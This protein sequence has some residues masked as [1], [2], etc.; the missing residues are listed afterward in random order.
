MKVHDTPG[1]A[2]QTPDTCRFDPSQN[3]NDSIP[4]N[5][6][7]LLGMTKHIAL[8]AILFH[9]EEGFVSDLKGK[10]KTSAISP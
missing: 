4:E 1:L 10:S 3:I 7:V 6:H 5:V 2:V 8:P 9:K